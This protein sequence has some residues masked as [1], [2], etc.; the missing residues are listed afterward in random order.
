MPTPTVA[1]TSAPSSLTPEGY[2]RARRALMRRDPVLAAAIKRIGACGMGDIA[3]SVLASVIGHYPHRNQA[4]IDA[5]ALAL[6][7][8]ISA[9]EFMPDAGYGV[10]KNFDGLAIEG[11]SQEHGFVSSKAP[12][13]YARLPIGSRVQVLPN[14]V[15][16]T[17][18]NHDKYYV[19]DSEESDG[20]T[21]VDIYDR[22]N[23]W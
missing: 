13:P 19:V 7:K 14:H 11:L 16:I 6:S 8:D 15:C 9:Q 21:V 10:V 1:S 5:G 20:R 17:A 3:V 23:G 18:G 12:F 4:L 2:D 22:V